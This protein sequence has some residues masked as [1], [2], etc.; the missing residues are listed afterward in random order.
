MHSRFDRRTKIW[1]Q[2]V[3][4]LIHRTKN[5]KMAMSLHKILKC[6]LLFHIITN[7]H[8][9]SIRSTVYLCH[10]FCLG[11]GAFILSSISQFINNIFT[12]W[13]YVFDVL[14]ISTYTRYRKA[15][16]DVSQAT[17]HYNILNVIEWC[18]IKTNTIQPNYTMKK[19]IQMKEFVHTP[20]EEEKIYLL[21]I[22]RICVLS[23]SG[24]NK[25]NEQKTV[26]N[27]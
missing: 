14:F 12:G 2:I 17:S 9:I 1:Q 26:A 11:D 6:I 13:P 21:H 19:R 24:L 25:K 23:R 27:K 10:I 15:A 18:T 4:N 8:F 5:A 7:T 3:D 20:L 16:S 22:L